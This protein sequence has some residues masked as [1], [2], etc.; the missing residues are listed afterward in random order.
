[1][2]IFFTNHPPVGH[3][4]KNSAKPKLP[5]LHNDLLQKS[6]IDFGIEMDVKLSMAAWLFLLKEVTILD[7]SDTDFPMR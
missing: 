4:T 1:L 6:W 2:C 5:Q 3:V 7:Q